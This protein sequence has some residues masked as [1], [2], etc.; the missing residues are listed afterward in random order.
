MA[1]CSVHT[2]A[3]TNHGADLNTKPN[4]RPIVTGTVNN[5]KVKFLVDSGASISVIAESTF[6]SLWQHWNFF[7]LPTP[8]H[9]RVQGITG[10][11]IQVVDYVMVEIEILGKMIRRPMVVVSGLDHT[12]AVLGWDTI[13]EEGLVVDGAKDRVYFGQKKESATWSVASLIL[14]R[15]RTI[16]PF[17]VHKVEV[18]PTV[19]DT[20]LPK[21]AVGICE[22]I[23][24]SEIGLWDSLGQVNGQNE[25]VMA[26]VNATDKPFELQAGD[27]VGVMRNPDSFEEELKPL[28]EE[29]LAS[30]FG[31]IGVD[32][33]PPKRGRV[34]TLNETDKD[35]LLKRLNVEAPAESKQA[36]L[37]LLMDY[38]DVCSKDKYDLGWTNVIE[39]SIQMK[40]MVP[41]HNRQFRVPFEHE[42]TLHKYV[43]ELLKQ[44]A[45]EV[46]RSPYNSAIFCVIKKALPGADENTPRPLRCVLDFRRINANSL[47][48]RYCM[49][50]VRECIDEI[51]RRGSSIYST[52]DLTSGFWQQALAEDSRQFTAFTV[53]GL[54]ARFQWRVTPMG[55]QGSPASFARLM[56]Y[57]MRGIKGVLTYIDDIL[58]H[59]TNH[60]EHLTHLEEVL[61][62]LRRYGLKLNVDKTIFAATS[63]QYLGYTLTPEGVTLSKDKLKAI[64]DFP[65]PRNVKQ[66]REF[67]GLANYFRFLIPNFSRLS[68][69]MTALTCKDAGWKEGQLPQ[70]AQTAFDK[71]K[72]A[73]TADPVVMHPRRGKPFILTTDG[74]LGDKD[75]VGGL[76][77]VLTQLDDGG[78][79]R[80]VAYASRTLRKHEKNYS[81]YLIE[82][83]AAV[84]G[85]EHFDT[86]LIGRRFTLYTDHRPM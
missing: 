22:A 79:E 25:L 41:L 32:P 77:A 75:N 83:A 3:E 39:H 14:K 21:D 74:S 20:V 34:K 45:I 11:K 81:A 18:V 15:R 35:M 58:V 57:I 66:I 49:K 63:V 72:A 4:R 5:N 16:M 17:S 42:E 19:G 86:Y 85:I 56:D 64:V 54:G 84:F 48:D 36:Y 28:N 9:F 37:N 73:L 38:H 43:E 24:G 13:H 52:V 53:P 78:K 46:S 31:Q 27:R 82:M 40:D 2:V 71:M 61:W 10:H 60:K 50:E 23:P 33:Q 59:S 12:Q 80:V 51:G 26:I 69:P 7:R 55:L 8:T 62:R 76:G 30:I 65:A 47:P 70:A 68:G 67:V 29:T 1:M 6:R 44:G